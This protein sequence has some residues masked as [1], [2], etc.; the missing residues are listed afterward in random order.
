MIWVILLEIVLS[1]K[2]TIDVTAEVDLQEEV[3][4]PVIIVV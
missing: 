4:L 1:Q 2:E 3:V